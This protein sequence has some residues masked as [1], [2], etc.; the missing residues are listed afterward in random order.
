[1]CIRDRTIFKDNLYFTAESYFGGRQ[2][3]SSNGSAGGTNKLSPISSLQ[4]F[5]DVEELTSTPD[6][7]FYTAQTSIPL[8]NETQTESQS[9]DSSA[10]TNSEA[11]STRSSIGRELWTSRGPVDSM[12]LVL[13]IYEGPGSSDPTELTAIGNVI[14]FSADD[15]AN[16]EELWT[17]DGT[18]VGT[19]RLTDINPGAKNSSPRDITA[20]DG[21]VY[22][23]AINEKTGREL[24]RLSE[25]SDSNSLARVVQAR[26]G[27]RSMRAMKQTKDEFVFNLPKEFGKNKADQIINFRPND[28][29]QIHLDRDIFEESGKRID[30]VTVS[31]N[32]QLKA[33]QSQP[34]QFIYF[35]PK[36]QLYFDRNDDQSG[37]GKNAGLFAILKGGPDLTESDFKII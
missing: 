37:Y 17:S 35:E 16:G 27:S 32:R 7:L 30:L 26:K 9:E 6:Q 3:W 20:M 1:M 18:D 15:G 31:S 25:S 8:E 22:F 11:S 13:D 34:S 24:W 28:G 23:T 29:D 5:S 10:D 12:K 33:Q 4:I 36:G 19:Q 2:V 14:Y 21:S